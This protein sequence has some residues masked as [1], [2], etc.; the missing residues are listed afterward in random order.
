MTDDELILRE[1]PF[2]T[3]A[4]RAANSVQDTVAPARAAED[5]Y[6]GMLLL[7]NA[8]DTIKS[9]LEGTRGTPLILAIEKGEI[10]ETIHDV[11]LD[12][13]AVLTWSPQRGDL[14]LLRVEAQSDISVGDFLTGAGDGTV[15]VIE[16]DEQD[17]A[18][19]Q[20]VS[21]CDATSSDEELLT[22]LVA[23]LVL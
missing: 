2:T 7:P 15:R 12:G 1:F 10:G 21:A 3:I 5:I 9:T 6:P 20:A 16:S 4:L 11:Y 17:V 19:F 23:A 18:L 14:A 22:P 8:T 13:E